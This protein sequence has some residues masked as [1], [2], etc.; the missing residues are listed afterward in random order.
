MGYLLATIESSLH[1]L[2]MT[3]ISQIPSAFVVLENNLRTSMH[4]PSLYRAAR[5]V[6]AVCVAISCAVPSGGCRKAA[7]PERFDVQGTVTF[8]GQPVPTGLLVLEPDA[9]KGN[10]GPVSVLEISNG[11]FDSR[12]PGAK[13]PLQGPLIARI[14]GYPEADPSVE[15]PKPLFREYQTTVDLAPDG[16][17][18]VLDFHIEKQSTP[19]R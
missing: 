18:S 1:F 10:G 9:S 7:G 17:V 11:R 4:R 5:P 12:Q 13:G 2:R 14:T 16:N 8:D 19:R 15:I 3:T 6:I